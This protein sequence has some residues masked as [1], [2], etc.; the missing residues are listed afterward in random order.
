MS[1][2]T[3]FKIEKEGETF[4]VFDNEQIILQG[5]P[6]AEMALHGLWSYMGKRKA[7]YYSCDESGQVFVTTEAIG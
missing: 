5:F 6:T 4:R 7:S 3:T 1:I 2:K